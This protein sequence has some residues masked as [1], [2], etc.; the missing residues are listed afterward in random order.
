MNVRSHAF[1]RALAVPLAGA[2]LAT[3][4][5]GASPAAPDRTPAP[6]APVVQRIDEGFDWGSAAIGAGSAGVLIV[7]VSVGGVGYRNRRD[8]IGVAR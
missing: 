4:T 6:D 8:R 3:P 2:S 1:P 7:L 5:A